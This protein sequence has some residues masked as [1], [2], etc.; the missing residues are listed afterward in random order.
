MNRYQ[1]ELAIEVRVTDTHV[2]AKTPYNEKFVT[3]ARAIGGKWN[4]HERKWTFDRR[5]EE[6]VR[7]L[8]REVFGT[9]G[10]PEDQADLVTVRIRAA[11][12]EQWGEIAFIGRKVAW[13][14]G[15]DTRVRLADNVVVVQGRFP[16]SGG[17]R[18]NPRVDAGDD[19]ILE[20]RD[21]PR[22]ALSVEKEGTYEIV[23]ETID[24]EALRAE[25]ERL[26]ARLTEIDAILN[27]K[28]D[29]ADL[30]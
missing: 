8:C 27:E 10:S 7:A 29:Q 30:E 16:S 4:R 17:S 24:K 19:V 23:E 28:S 1:Q 13:R 11:D 14:P 12:Y 9:D 25:R 6:R 20:I 18:N 3:G 15:R 26:L 2:E 5:D 22:A 21:I